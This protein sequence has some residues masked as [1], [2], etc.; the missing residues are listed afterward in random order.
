MFFY[1]PFCISQ[2]QST[3]KKINQ[4]SGLSNG[5]VNCIVKE[6]NGFVWI[7]TSNGLNRY[8]GSKIKVYNKQNNNL[9]SNDISDLLI[10]SKGRIWIATMG[11]GLNLYLPLEDRFVTYI[12]KTEK[13]SSIISSEINTIFEDSKS[14]LWL[15]TKNGLS[16]FNE[17]TKT[18]RSYIYQSE[19]SQS[20]SHNDVRSICED[21]KGNLWIGTFGGGINRFN[22]ETEIF[23]HVNA[24]N[25]LSSNFIYTIE[26]LNKDE[27]LIGTSGEGLLALNLKSLELSKSKI[28]NLESI[29]IVRDIKKDINGTI[30]VGTDGDGIFKI[31]NANSKNPVVFNFKYN[32][33]LE[34]SISS[35]AIY[36]FMEDENSNIWIGTA[37]N[38]VNV[39]NLN[40]EY[41]FFSS[42]GLDDIPSPVLSVH[43]KENKIFMGLDGRG[44]LI[45]DSK[46]GEITNYGAEGKKRIQGNYIQHIKETSDATLWLGT[47]VNGLINFDTKT[48]VSYQYKREVDNSNS[49]SHNDVRYVVEDNKSN[50]WVA[51]WGGGLNYFNSNTKE[52]I[53]FINN[54]EDSLS[55][56]NNNVISLQKDKNNLWLATFG[57]GLNYFDLKTKQFEHYRHNSNDS[58][59]ISSD[60]IYSILKDS[61]ENL[62][63]G[64]SGEGVNLFNKESRKFDR[65]ENSDDIRFQTIIA[66]IEDDN[67]LIWFSS[68]EGI[69]NYD[70]STNS[71]ERFENLA[72]EYHINSVF[73]DEEGL[74]YFG[75][76]KGVV[77]FNPSTISA[78]NSCPKVKITNLKLFNEEVAIGENKVLTESISYAKSITLEY[79]L[80][81]V[82]FEFAAMKFPSSENCE[83]AIQL[84]G[85]DKNWRNIGKDR[86][87]TYTNLSPDDYVFKV[88][89]REV[90]S[91]WEN[92]YT[93]IGVVVLNPLWL[94]WWAFVIYGLLI[95][96]SFYLFRKYIV[97]WEKMKNNL[98]LEKL[99]HEKD[100]ELY[101]LKQQFFTNISHEIRTPV[102]LILGSINRL[103]KTN[104]FNDTKEINPIYTI[105]NNSKHLLG[106]INELLDFRKLEQ[107]R[108]KLCATNN[109]FVSF[110]KEI[111][112]SFSDE[113]IHNKIKF[114]FSST[115]PIMNIWFD[116][117]QMEKV[118]YNL[119]SNSFKFTEN[120][121][122][123]NIDISE[124][125]EYVM[126][127]LTDQG[128]GI[129]T[130]QLSKI[131][132][133]FHQTKD[134]KAISAKGFGLGLTISKEIIEL[135]QGEIIVE[136][137]KGSGS[138]FTIK[139]K[140][141]N[142]H[143]NESEIGGDEVDSELIENYFIDN[144]ES[145]KELVSKNVPETYRDKKQ[146]LLIV[147]DNKDILEYISELL[148]NEFN[149]LR[150]SDGRE[151]LEKAI[152]ELPELI[153]SDVMM[154]IMD[155]MSLTRE[156]K[157]NVQT[158][159][160]PII[161]LTARTSFSYKLEGFETG[162]D[163]YITKP[164]NEQL[165]R[166]RIKNILKNRQ[167]LQEKFKA[168]EIPLISELS[169]NK[170]DQEFLETI[171]YLIKENIGS[172][173]LN[174]N[175]LITELGMSHSV[176]YKKLKS[177]TGLTIQEYS[178]DFKLKTAKK[179]ITTQNLSVA[180][181]SYMVGYS[182]RKYFSKLFKQ[183]FG[184]N[185]SA[186]LVKK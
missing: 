53:R 128:I 39:L 91:E 74:L 62:W 137:K 147:E 13:F 148:S 75:G 51:T 14:N 156:I 26:N 76:A 171:T 173:K 57:G 113:A 1:A 96:L 132:N 144:Q 55:I 110:C 87:V 33:Q 140:K 135:H 115:S 145:L 20:I 24:S 47:F 56:S 49:L 120:S 104:N 186:Y 161:L 106:L 67:G 121:K 131:F 45:V 149:I 153:V 162:A 124:N 29:S 85:F 139:L 99:T 18:F 97:A 50:L 112:L 68:K 143:F 152:N 107:N 119:L 146:T 134:S 170:T 108:I 158:S 37:W 35:N 7:G 102:T 30:W 11:G 182:D 92:E 175:F 78:K 116:K 34:S 160:I 164:F 3:F 167:L 172:E 151:G 52:F 155:G 17:K 157:S 183:R 142:D 122:S 43:K 70:Y 83:Y 40:K 4:S 23:Q 178:T 174:T 86:T 101:N 59:S 81:V 54:A 133:R 80:D 154:P 179:L 176:V 177:L 8:D 82:T 71:F 69:F 129:S 127:I 181:V 77:K 46:K 12:N 94:K 138:V 95:L 126:L 73:K 184:K 89:S 141:G 90:G 169:I 117:N 114:K 118:L 150:A 64:T 22:P 10:D 111:Y 63:V 38:G 180:D 42:N 5:R 130:Q 65:L 98:K 9:S 66:I 61:K 36:D 123:I 84:D 41:E 15:G 32:S 125:D 136:S 109:D 159:H 79:D 88:K 103:L 21:Q 25:G 185:P 100:I 28:G 93:S 19:N 105:K 58:T 165:L 6:K 31:E 163:D 166:G 16:L 27:I 48:G 168:E 44:L 72:G 2:A 60:Y